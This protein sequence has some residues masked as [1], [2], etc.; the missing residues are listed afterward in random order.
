MTANTTPR[1]LVHEVRKLRPEN[2][3]KIYNVWRRAVNLIRDAISEMETMG[4]I[5][6]LNKTFAAFA[7]IGMCSWTF[8]WFNYE[9]KESSDELANTYSEIFL[10]GLLRGGDDKK[11]R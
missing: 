1:V 8:Y 10:K 3:E 6:N 9:R 5:K 4:K 2:R 11:F 7:A